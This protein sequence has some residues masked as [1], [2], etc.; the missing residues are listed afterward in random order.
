MLLVKIPY[1]NINNSSIKKYNN[2]IEQIFKQKALDII[3]NN[4]SKDVFYTVDYFA[5][6]NENHILSI[7]IRSILKEGDKQHGKEQN[8]YY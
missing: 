7:V 3:N 8:F 4:E 6:I 5:Y 1:I 2:Q